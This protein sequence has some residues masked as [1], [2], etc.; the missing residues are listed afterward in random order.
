MTAN[1]IIPY[2]YAVENGIHIPHPEE[3]TVVR[4]I[5]TDYLGGG[6]LLTIAK[7]LTAESVEFLPGRS[8]W[9][10]N[11]IKRILEDERYIGTDTYPAIID[12]D[13]HR[14]ALTVKDSNNIKQ[15]KSERPF[16]PPC[17]VECVLCGAPMKRRHDSRRKTAQEVWTCQNPECHV[18]INIEDNALQSHIVELMN[19][20]I[21][22]PDLVEVGSLS[23][24]EPTAEVRRLQNE[25]DRELDAFEFDKDKTKKVIFAL[26][27]EKYRH[28]N[29]KP[30]KA[31]AV[32]AEFE[33]A[34]LLSSF[35]SELFTLTVMKIQLGKGVTRLIL[36]NQQHIERSDSNATSDNDQPA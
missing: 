2:G 34:N 15:I 4:R 7:A 13:M 33:K 3:S 12:A 10:K 29:N 32:R 21:E 17:P 23:K 8:D 16:R 25:V 9:N 26:A 36:K 6:S 5:F 27:S 11:R 18:I 28:I 24:T 35:L 1:R 14:Q 19:R 31:Y 30:Y 20:L 22:N